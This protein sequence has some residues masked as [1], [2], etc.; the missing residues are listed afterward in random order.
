MGKEVTQA[1]SVDT[2]AWF[3]GKTINEV[4]FCE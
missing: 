3:D 1:A 2:A 4:L